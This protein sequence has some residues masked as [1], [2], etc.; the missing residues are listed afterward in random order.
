MHNERTPAP[1]TVPNWQARCYHDTTTL[2]HGQRQG[3][4]CVVCVSPWDRAVPVGHVH[5]RDGFQVFAC[6]GCVGEVPTTPRPC[7]GAR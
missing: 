2:N 1:G 3:F 5:D 4:L 6:D 7:G